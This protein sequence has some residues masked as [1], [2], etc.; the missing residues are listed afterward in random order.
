LGT[1]KNKPNSS[2]IN[3]EMQ[4]PRYVAAVLRSWEQVKDEGMEEY[5]VGEER[6]IEE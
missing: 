4:L 6:L 1:T 5:T 2:Q 3:G